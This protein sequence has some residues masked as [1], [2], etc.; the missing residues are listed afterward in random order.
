[1]S[2]R[3]S[4]GVSPSDPSTREFLS[5]RGT[6]AI[7]GYLLA[8]VGTVVV[9]AAFV[10]FRG[11]LSPLSEG[12]VF[13]TLVVVT[14]AVGGLAPGIAASTLGFLAFNFFF[15]PPYDTFRIAD[16]KNLVMLFAFLGL[17]ILISVLIAQARARPEAAEARELELLMQQNLT[18]AL[19]EPR[20]GSESYDYVLR[21]IV[22]RFRF[23]EAVLMVQPRA[24]LGGLEEVSLVKADPGPASTAHAEAMEERFV[25]N[26]GRRNL[27]LL[28][29]RGDRPPLTTSER[30]ILEAFSNQLALVLERDRL[31]RIVVD[32]SSPGVN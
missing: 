22:S 7:V 24:D 26:I 3:T 27:G 2:A 14:V 11:D 5:Q 10:P 25:L 13:L 19:V 29:L 28:T 16:A 17:S 21:L 18:Y 20:P 30:R 4:F 8:T 12:F 15:I 6:R 31:L 1:M 32:G 23:H 9:V